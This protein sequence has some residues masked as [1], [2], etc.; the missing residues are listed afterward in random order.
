MGL[1]GKKA[2]PVQPPRPSS[3]IIPM[4]EPDYFESIHRRLIAN[5]GDLSSTT[6]AA[7]VGNAIY[8]VGGSYLEK[9]GAIREARDFE[10]LYGDRSQGDRTAADRMID[11]LV[12]QNPSLQAGDGAF[13]S[14]LLTRLEN[15]LSKP[16]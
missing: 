9:A 8:N 14:T 12:T 3:R 15:V 2:A 7:G 5:G 10:A 16:E 11:F 1:F 4:L 6:I 13:L